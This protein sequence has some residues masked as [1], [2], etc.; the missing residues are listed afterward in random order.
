MNV[1]QAAA[2][3]GEA[4]RNMLSVGANHGSFQDIDAS[5]SLLQRKCMSLS[6][7][8][9]TAEKAIHIKEDK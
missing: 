8:V 2:G 5:A 7:A 9:I 3:V 1:V 6:E 4:V